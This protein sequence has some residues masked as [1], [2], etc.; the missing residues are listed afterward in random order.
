MAVL[1]IILF[2]ESKLL[3]YA[4]TA[5]VHGPWEISPASWWRIR[6]GVPNW[7]ILW[8]LAHGC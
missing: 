4:K 1:D 5:G 3:D 8:E 2:G 7:L 6:T